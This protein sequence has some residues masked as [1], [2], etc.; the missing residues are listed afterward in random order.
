MKILFLSGWYPYPADNGS[1]VRIYGLLKG[2]AQQHE[3]TLLSFDDSIQPRRTPTE[4]ATLCREVRT[5]P[6]KPFNPSGWRARLGYLSPKPR[7][8]ADT[9]SPALAQSIR[10]LLA[11]NRFDVIIASQ[12][13][14]AMYSTLFRGVP[15]IFEELE[16]G[17]FHD[18]YWKTTGWR[19]WRS[20]LTWTKH[21]HWIAG[22]LKDFSA[23]T[24]VSRLEQSLA[25]SAIPHYHSFEVVPNSVELA[26]YS[27]IDEVPQPNTLVFTGSF[28][29][30]PN[31]DAMSWFLSEVLP[32]IQREVPDVQLTITGNN[33]G[34]ALPQVDNVH[35]TGYVDDVRPY[36]A[37]SWAAIVPIR[38]GGGTRLKILEAMA[39][40][41]PVITTSKGAEGLDLRDGQDL[42]LADRPE[43]FAQAVVRVLCEPRLRSKL[44][45]AAY[46]AVRTQ[47]DGKVVLPRFLDLVERVAAAPVHP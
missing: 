21:K 16:L 22:M 32:L 8:V 19:R 42:L 47:Y 3:V 11:E 45:D 7:M 38:Y 1:K 29:Y 25:Q 18:A 20:G 13:Q 46:A 34:Y 39:L 24:V 28:S 36:I 30:Y 9:Y 27:G 26:H 17:I 10:Q 14:T 35:L 5:V 40:H 23:C 31:Y 37:R 4:L 15:A 43:D 33:A 12:F 2:L 41:T 6:W 44:A